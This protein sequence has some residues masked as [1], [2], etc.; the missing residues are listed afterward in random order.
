M[1]D[2]T[3]NTTKPTLVAE[4][5]VTTLDTLQSLEIENIVEDYQALTVQE[6]D[7]LENILTTIN[8]VDPA[9][10]ISYGAQTMG[11]ISRFS[12]S[13]LDRVKAKD[14][15]MIGEELTNLRMK[16]KEFDVGSIGNKK[17]FWSNI[18]VIGRLFNTVDHALAHFETLNTQVEKIS[19]RLDDAMVGLLRDSETLEQLFQHNKKSYYEMNLYIMAGR[20]KIDLVNEHELP[21]A[22]ALAAESSNA[23]AP[24]AVR[25]LVERVHAFE[26]RL[27]DLTISRTLA[28]QTAPQI[29]LMQ[30]NNQLLAEKIQT[31]LLTMIPIWK[32]QI[33]LA[34]AIQNQRS[35]AGL[36][37]ELTDTTNNM[38]R[39]NAEMLQQ[40]TLETA[41]EVERAI[42]D[43]ETIREVQDRLLNTIDETINIVNEARSR[44]ASVEKELESMEQELHRR[45][46]SASNKSAAAV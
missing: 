11:E 46:V 20:K 16:V 21:K 18:P 7:R 37:K 9:L 45:L 4:P 27:H 39:K 1:T 13:M 5:A 31:S 25:D 44:R 41:R 17:S 24:Q 14:A 6:Q 38:L 36:Q 40:G 8:I 15:G 2:S 35:A 19:A 30:N 29:R 23:M 42:I 33:V 22:Q 12:S 3:E 28:V 34:L 10:S 26:R 43:V 32:N